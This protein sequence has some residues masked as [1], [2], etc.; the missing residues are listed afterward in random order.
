MADSMSS[1]ILTWT[2]R[3]LS[4]LIAFMF[5]LLATD[6]FH[7]AGNKIVQFGDFLIHLLPC[8]LVIGASF[9][10]WY[11]PKPGGW[12]FLILAASYLVTTGVGADL[13]AHLVITIPLAVCGI[14]FLAS[15][16]LEK[17]ERIK[18]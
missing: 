3:V 8:F 7:Q 2:P 6:A 4:A 12:A 10:A 16:W 13:Q 11:W 5:G 9:T 17:R 18:E 1:K 14:L 15:A